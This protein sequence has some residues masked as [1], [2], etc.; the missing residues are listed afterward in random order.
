MSV[1]CRWKPGNPQGAEK[2]LV[3]ACTNRCIPTGKLPADV[4]CLVMNITSVAFVSNY[5]KTG[6]PLVTKRV[7]VDGSAIKNPQNVIVPIGTKIADIIAFCGG[8]KSEPK[9]ILMGGPMMGLALTSDQLPVLKQNNGILVF[10]EKYARLMKPSSCIRC[11]KCV[12]N[13]PMQLVPTMLEKYAEHQDVDALNQ[14]GVM[15]C[16]ECGT[17]AY[18]CPAGRPL[19]QAIRFGKALVKKAGGKK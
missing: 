12:Q 19:V 11:G 7:T 17:C 2:V 4:G 18:N 15:T 3:Q 1:S 8:Y 9:K 10:D 16:M 6:M 13:C 14:Y 5:L